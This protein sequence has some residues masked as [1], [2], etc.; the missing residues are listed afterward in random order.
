MLEFICYF[1][2]S[3]ISLVIHKKLTKNDKIENI[4]LYYGVYLAINN[5]M[6]LILKNIN[7]LSEKIT[8][9]MINVTYCYKYLLVAIIISIVSPY[10]LYMIS[11]NINIGIK[12]VKNEKKKA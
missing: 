4:V 10:I 3:F 7:H 5:F 1:T 2:P 6:T 8:F 9:E 12:A 11:K